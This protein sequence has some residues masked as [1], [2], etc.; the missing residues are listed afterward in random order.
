MG[1]DECG[2]KE[3]FRHQNEVPDSFNVYL[4]H[5]FNKNKKLNQG[6]RIVHENC[7]L[8]YVHKRA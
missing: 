4:G 8:L 1:D 2:I 3:N 5:L 7:R 6:E